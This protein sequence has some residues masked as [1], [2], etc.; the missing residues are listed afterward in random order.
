[1]GFRLR[2]HLFTHALFGIPTTNGLNDAP[3]LGDGYNGAL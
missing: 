2:R 3:D 1:M